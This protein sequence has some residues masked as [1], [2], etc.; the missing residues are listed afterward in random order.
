MSSTKSGT[1]RYQFLVK[2]ISNGLTEITGGKEHKGNV[3]FFKSVRAFD[4]FQTGNSKK[5]ESVLISIIMNGRRRITDHRVILYNI[6]PLF[7]DTI[8]IRSPA[9]RDVYRVI[10]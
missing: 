10:L 2:I 8:W 3:T 7:N 6:L 4:V 1:G 9:E 5:K